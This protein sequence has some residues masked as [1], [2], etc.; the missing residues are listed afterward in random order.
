[1]PRKTTSPQ[2]QLNPLQRMFGTFLRMER[3]RL[4]LSS[5][6]VA[7]RLQVTDTYLR[8]AEAGRAA[9]NQSLAFKIIEVFADSDAQTHE[10]R[11]ISFNRLAL[12]MV[13]MHWVGAEMAG[14]NESGRDAVEDLGA[15]VSDFQVFFDR[16]N[17]YFELP[18]GKPEQKGFLEKVASPAVGVF[19]RSE[20]YGRDDIGSLEEMSYQGAI[21]LTSQL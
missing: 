10:F 21:S 20:S 7:D 13:G 15:R 4:G 6:C 8:L 18:E 1:M 9:L 16:T 14:H 11:T 17:E 3:T 12:F 19:L 5:R 2:N